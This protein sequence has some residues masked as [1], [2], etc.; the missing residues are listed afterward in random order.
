MREIRTYGSEGGEA[1]PSR[2]LSRK[3]WMPASSLRVA[4][5]LGGRSTWMKLGQSLILIRI[6]V[7]WEQRLF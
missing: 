1:Q 4:H 7:L 6:T 3:T 2:P 5:R